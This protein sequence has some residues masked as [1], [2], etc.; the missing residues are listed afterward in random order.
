M[1]Q[2]GVPFVNAL[3]VTTVK[4]SHRSAL[5]A[6][7]LAAALA[8]LAAPSVLGAQ[9]AIEDFSRAH[10][11]IKAELVLAVVLGLIVTAMTVY[12]AL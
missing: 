12:F 6:A 5:S 2:V 7:G 4:A 10:P 1:R 8:A 3:E 9:M 11:G